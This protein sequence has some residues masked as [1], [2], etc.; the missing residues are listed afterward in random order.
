MNIITLIFVIAAFVLFMIAAF[1]VPSKWNLIALGLAL[2]MLSL[3][4]TTIVHAAPLPDRQVAEDQREY[5]AMRQWTPHERRRHRQ[6]VRRW[7]N[8]QRA[9]V[10]RHP[11]LIL[12]Y[13]CRRG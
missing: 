8:A 12:P 4:A 6:E 11:R 13:E 10:D 1:N 5:N 7:C 2:Y 3:F 9:K